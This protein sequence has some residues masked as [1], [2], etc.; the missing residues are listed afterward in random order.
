MSKTTIYI[1]I[2]CLILL[3]GGYYIGWLDNGPREQEEI[4][5]INNLPSRLDP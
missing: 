4:I 1:I 3:I 2:A 5:D